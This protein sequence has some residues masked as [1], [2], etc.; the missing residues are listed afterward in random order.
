M[1]VPH[2]LDVAPDSA[3]GPWMPPDI[4]RWAA[5]QLELA[6]SIV[7]NPGGGLLF[8]T[9]TMGQVKAALAEHDERR[10]ASVVAE[11]DLAEDLT[12]RREFATARE[13]IEAARAA[14][15]AGAD[16]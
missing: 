2:E 3:H 16:R 14:L 13:R 11:L 10:W 12:V 5:R 15:G 1:N 8:A 9:Q 6:A 7:D 4:A